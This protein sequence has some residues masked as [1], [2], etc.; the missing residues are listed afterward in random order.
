MVTR[1]GV[2][3]HKAYFHLRLA[4]EVVL[5]QPPCYRVE[6][7][8]V[9]VVEEGPAVVMIVMVVHF[10]LLIPPALSVR[11]CSREATLSR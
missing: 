4:V 7:M 3:A 8:V 1:R 6:L 10:G 5:R 11:A 9:A 2:E